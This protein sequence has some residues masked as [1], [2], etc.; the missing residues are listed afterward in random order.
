MAISNVDLLGKDVFMRLLTTQLQYQDPLAPMDST[1]FVTQL[2]QFTQLEQ[3]NGINETLGSL[4]NVNTSLNKYGAAGLIGREVQ[5]EGK[6]VILS[7]DNQAELRYRMKQD[8]GTVSVQIF[9]EG[10]RVVRVL[11]GGPQK[12]GLQ[13]LP[14]DGRDGNGNRLP[15]GAYSF[16]VAGTSLT[17]APIEGTSFSS[18]RVT[19]VT[20][21]EGIPFLTVNGIEVP[22][23]GVI[24]IHQT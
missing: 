13:T 19:G 3:M 21:P 24:A 1:E 2:A 14:W 6:S 8:A 11:E 4:V 10:G 7:Q 9:D 15:E 22:A 12:A 16:D 20:Y 5:V 18:G 23:S 17:G